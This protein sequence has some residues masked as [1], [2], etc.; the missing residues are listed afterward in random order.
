MP[1][2]AP[3]PET[4]DAVLEYF[5]NRIPQA[6]FAVEG[7]N[8]LTFSTA[9]QY[10]DRYSAWMDRHGVRPGDRI[11]LI[12]APGIPYVL[13]LMAASRLGAIYV[14]VNP[15]YSRDEISHVIETT[16]PTILLHAPAP[17]E[18]D[19]ATRAADAAG[20][21]PVHQVPLAAI[22]EGPATPRRSP[23]TSRDVAVIVFTSGSTGRPKGAALHHGGL[24]GASH[25]QHDHLD[26][27]PRRYLSNLPINHVGAIMNT[28]MG[29]L[30]GGGTL[31]FQARFNPAGVLDLI[32][33]ERVQTWLQVPAMFTMAVNHADF[34]TRDLSSLRS[35]CIGGG[36]VSAP[37]LERLRSTGAEIFVEYGQTEVM[38]SL[39][40]SDPGAPDEVLLNSIGR[41]D[42]RFETR[43]ADQTGRSCGTGEIGE[44]QARGDCVLR[45]YWGNEQA[46]R[47][48]F[49]VDGWLRTGDLACL[50]PDGNV[51]IK[52]RLREMI[53]SGGYNVYP[54]EVEATIETHPAVAEVV[55]FGIPDEVFGEAVHCAIECRPGA[56]VTGEALKAHCAA[57]LANYKIPKVF[58]VSAALPR[59][60]NGKI[61]RAAIRTRG[62]T[63]AGA[64]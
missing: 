16:Q 25:G 61:D 26:G 39:S 37:T 27:E 48:A 23:A 17:G 50:R 49:T 21:I 9:N 32:E 4:L 41:F 58:A 10:V 51:S 30:I 56:T 31:I 60:G 35:I 6:E 64:A 45:G 24:I 40:Y 36:A 38:S 14:G 46:T 53:K 57:S 7:R 19:L 13:T 18:G 5:S 42:P 1:T 3:F 22:A 59:L 55:V 43:I 33:R 2:P 34:D 52:G 12:A 8:R 28:T 54:R 29:C 15:R 62:A 47:D 11:A 44:I 63:T 20:A